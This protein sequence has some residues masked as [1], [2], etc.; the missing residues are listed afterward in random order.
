MTDITETWRFSQIL[1]DAAQYRLLRSIYET[2]PSVGPRTAA[3]LRM[4]FASHRDDAGALGR[5][6]TD[7]REPK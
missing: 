3:T 4:C 7:G 5:I 2:D 6:A 1:V